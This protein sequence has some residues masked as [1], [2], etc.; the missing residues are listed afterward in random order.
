MG[1]AGATAFWCLV[2]G[3]RK[4]E[5][6]VSVWNMKC[7]PFSHREVETVRR[8]AAVSSCRIY[9]GRPWNRAKARKQS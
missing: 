1:E 5:E 8:V 3:K 9:G 7:V 6:S 4:N 2:K